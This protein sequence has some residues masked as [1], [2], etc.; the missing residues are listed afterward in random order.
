MTC[1]G[2]VFSISLNIVYKL[3][4]YYR[5]PS[6]SY[7]QLINSGIGH[8]DFAKRWKQPGDEIFTTVPSFIYPNDSNR[9]DFYA[10][11]EINIAKA[12]NIRLQFVNVAY[13]FIK[14]KFT[15]YANVS[16]LGIIWKAD[17]GGLDPDYPN[18]IPPSKSFTIGLR[19]SF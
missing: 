12:D 2:G 10:W 13:S 9:D 8:S 17:K 14:S 4:Y 3:G 11:S 5:K 16:N 7:T 15:V 18:T 19:G 1:P 6:L